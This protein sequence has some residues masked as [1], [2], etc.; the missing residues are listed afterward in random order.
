MIL[1]ELYLN[2][3][4]IGKRRSD[5]KPVRKEKPLSYHPQNNYYKIE[6]QNYL[7]EFM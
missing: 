7:N 4:R 5:V 6:Q 2:F 3:R 1:Y